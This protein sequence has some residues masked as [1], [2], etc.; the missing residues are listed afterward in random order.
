MV[1]DMSSGDEV[2][3]GGEEDAAELDLAGT[4]GWRLGELRKGPFCFP[5][6]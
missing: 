2:S 4:T 1:R 6:V 3:G 5:G